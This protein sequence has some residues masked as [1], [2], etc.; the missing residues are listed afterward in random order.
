MFTQSPRQGFAAQTARVSKRWNRGIG[1]LVLPKPAILDQLYPAHTGSGQV[2]R[3]R[4]SPW[5][6]AGDENTAVRQVCA[7]RS[8][9]VA[10]RA[11]ESPL[12]IPACLGTMGICVC[13]LLDQSLSAEQF[14]KATNMA[15]HAL[16]KCAGN[17]DEAA[18]AVQKGHNRIDKRPRVGSFKPDRGER[19][20]EHEPRV[21]ADELPRYAQTCPCFP[22]HDALTSRPQ[23]H[24]RNPLLRP[25]L[26]RMMP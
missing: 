17:L 14:Q 15:T 16:W 7:R 21:A 4:R 11:Q 24:F 1:R 10:E 5:L 9:C 23:R 2:T 8:G 6:G 20:V 18:G 3:G 22:A 12:R 26:K 19:G 25:Q 13:D